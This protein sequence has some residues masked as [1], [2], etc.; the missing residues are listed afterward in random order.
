[1]A[2]DPA[3]GEHVLDAITDADLAI[4]EFDESLCGQRDEAYTG[5]DFSGLLSPEMYRRFAIPQYQRIYAGRPD[6][7]MHSEL[8]RAEHLRIA[9]DMLQ[10]TSFHGAGCENLTLAEMHDIMGNDFWTQIT[11]Q[12]L[13][14]LSPQAI[15]EKVKQYADCGAGYVQL[16]P[17]RG[18][19]DANMIAA[20]AAADRHCTGGRA[21]D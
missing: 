6:R 5:D 4:R 7:S 8:L 18:T 9:K 16:Y 21:G 3:T 20:I 17:G 15:T 2:E 19:P 11:P 1:M 10:I 12:E 13:V 14:E